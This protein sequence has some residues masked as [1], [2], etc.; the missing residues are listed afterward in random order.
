MILG[1]DSW[2]PF[3]IIY[4][5]GFQGSVEPPMSR[6]TVLEAYLNIPG[7]IS[8]SAYYTPSLSNAANQGSIS[9]DHSMYLWR[10]VYEVSVP[11][12]DS[13]WYLAKLIQLCKV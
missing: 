8:V 6:Y 5:Y 13:F 1:K 3:Q 10:P 9:L 7:L 2:S 4:I 12:A 11:V